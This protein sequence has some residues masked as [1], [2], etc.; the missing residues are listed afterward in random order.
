LIEMSHPGESMQDV[1]FSADSLQLIA[2]NSRGDVLSWRVPSF[3][4]I[5]QRENRRAQLK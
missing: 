4:E 5:A 3:D 1:F 2:R